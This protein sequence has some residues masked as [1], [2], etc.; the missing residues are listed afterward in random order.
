MSTASRSSTRALRSNSCRSLAR[1]AEAGKL[2]AYSCKRESQRVGK[3]G[4]R[5]GRE[6]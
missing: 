2:T 5:A 1:I 6:G 4:C 3:R